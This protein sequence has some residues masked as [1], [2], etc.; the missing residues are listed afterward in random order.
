MDSPT[1]DNASTTIDLT[2]ANKHLQRL[3]NSR[4]FPKTICPSEAARALTKDELEASG[5]FEW[6]D[7]MTP[8]RQH[9]FELRDR[10]KLEILQ[11]GSVLPSDQSMEETRGPIRLRLLKSTTA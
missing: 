4:A 7:L 11:Q 9:A 6:R 1:D 5:A 10:G 3:L 8:L 2:I